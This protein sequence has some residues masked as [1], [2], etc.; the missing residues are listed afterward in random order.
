MEKN[1]VEYILEAK[2]ALFSN[3]TLSVGGEKCSYQG[4]TY[5]AIKR[6]TE[7]I[8]WKPTIEWVID[9]VTVLNQ[10]DYETKAVVTVKEMDTSKRDLSYYTFLKNVKYLVK[11]HFEWNENFD[12]FKKDR[13]TNKHREIFMRSLSKGGRFKISAGISECPAFVYPVDKEYH[14]FYENT[15]KYPIG[16]MYISKGYPNENKNGEEKFFVY[17]SNIIMEKGVIVYPKLEYCDKREIK[18]MKFYDF[19][20]KEVL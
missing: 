12:K 10:I 4:P 18:E 7:N 9:S 11:A 20:N 2:Y 1:K 6:I 13:I 3:P 15:E 16:Y 8:Y 19:E 14:S 5:E 17:L